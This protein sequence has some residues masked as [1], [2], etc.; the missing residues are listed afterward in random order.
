MQEM[1]LLERKALGPRMA[2]DESH[3][4]AL[5]ALLHS[6]STPHLHITPTALHMRLCASSSWPSSSAMSSRVYPSI[7]YRMRLTRS[8]HRVARVRSERGYHCMAEGGKHIQRMDKEPR[9]QNRWDGNVRRR[10]F[11]MLRGREI[12]K[13]T[14]VEYKV[15]RMARQC[16][17][18]DAEGVPLAKQVSYDIR[19]N[20]DE[21]SGRPRD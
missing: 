1:A 2:S 20:Q 8:L 14:R 7:W 11:C 19:E 15:H 17:S 16:E 10:S 4:Y 18:G 12:D 6:P 21:E 13:R 5:K 9:R 3:Q